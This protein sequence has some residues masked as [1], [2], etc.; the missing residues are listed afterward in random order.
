MTDLVAFRFEAASIAD[1]DETEGA[2]T[3]TALLAEQLR[4]FSRQDILK[5]LSA[6]KFGRPAGDAAL[7]VLV[8]K[9][10]LHGPLDKSERQ[11]GERGDWYTFL[12]P[13][14]FVPDAPPEDPEAEEDPDDDL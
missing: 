5:A 12:R 8:A 14:A 11:K 9:G 2:V 3:A 7:K 4:R 1:A 10:V 6:K 13:L